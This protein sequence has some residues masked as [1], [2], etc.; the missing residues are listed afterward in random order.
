MRTW[1]PVALIALSAL[2]VTTGTGCATAARDTHGFAIERSA[3]VD[4]PFDEAWQ[5]TKHTLQDMELG[6]YTRDKRGTFVAFS[7]MDRKLR[8]LTPYR[9]KITVDLDEVSSESTRV[10]VSTIKQIYGVTLLTYPDWHDRK[11]TD[12]ALAEAILQ[13]LQEKLAGGP[14]ESV[15]VE[16]ATEAGE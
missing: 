3:V 14:A 11:M 16:A 10:T 1:M 15:D 8:L 12:P 7:D 4:A 2:V 9:T 5:A 13:H 6:L